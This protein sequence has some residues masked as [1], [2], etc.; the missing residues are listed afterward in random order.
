MDDFSEM[1]DDDGYLAQPT[2]RGSANL[3]VQDYQGFDGRSSILDD[4]LFEDTPSRP[5][6]GAGPASDI[7]GLDRYDILPEMDPDDPSLVATTY[8]AHPWGPGA[9]GGYRPFSQQR[10]GMDLNSLGDD[11][12]ERKGSAEPYYDQMMNEPEVID[13]VAMEEALPWGD[14]WKGNQNQQPSNADVDPM[15]LYDRQSYERTGSSQNVIGN[16]IFDMEEGVTW[17]ARDGQFMNQYALPAYLSHDDMAVEQSPMWDS[18]AAEWRVTQPTASGV[19]LATRTPHLKPPPKGLRPEVTGPRS[20]IEAFGRKAARCVMKECMRHSHVQDRSRFLVGVAEALGPG[21]AAQA[22]AIADKLVAMG[23]R[24]EVALED[25]LAHMLMHAVKD[26]LVAKGKRNKSTLPRL[27]RVA[28]LMVNEKPQMQAA[29]SE[30]IAP[31]TKDGNKLRDDLGRLYASP[32]ARGMGMVG[33]AP[34]DPA[35]PT[36]SAPSTVFTKRNLILG[37]ALG[38]GAYLVFANRK[39]IAKNIKKVF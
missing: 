38:L 24:K 21:R 3:D 12:P 36:E 16:G 35:A 1:F 18:T 19:T 23:Y 10:A 6:R 4:E 8:G 7:E 14:A 2:M 30:H 26:D 33:D 15:T 13:A 17:H 32:A 22:Q 28:K 11:A 5:G 29:A 34:A 20:H 37:G 25:T 31:L 39:A 27:D 9:K